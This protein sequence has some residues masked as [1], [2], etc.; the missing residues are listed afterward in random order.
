MSYKLSELFAL[1]ESGVHYETAGHDVNYAFKEEGSTLY[2][3]FQG[4]SGAVDWFRNFFFFPTSKKPYRDMD[5][6]YK[7]HSGFLAAW[8][9]VEDIIINKVTE[10]EGNGFKWKHITVV[11]YSHGGSLTF[12][13]TECVWYWRPDL[14]DGG[15]ESYAFESP[16]VFHGWHIPKRLKCR[17]ANMTVIRTGRDL[18]THL[19]PHLFR[20]RHVTKNQR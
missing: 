10:K 12:F 11:G 7:V 6:P 8:K 3:F 13:T 15:F 5:E 4:S 19:P 17:W 1:C 16:R 9:E 2:I 18:V 14:R 20:F